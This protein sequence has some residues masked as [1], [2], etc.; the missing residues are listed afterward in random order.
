MKK[1]RRSARCAVL[2]ALTVLGSGVP[3]LAQGEHAVPMI[4]MTGAQLR[5]Q[6]IAVQSAA[7]AA[8]P[9]SCAIVGS[10]DL[11]VSNEMLAAFKARD[12]TLESL[13]LGITSAF[14]FDPESGKPMP[15]A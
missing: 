9:N 6:G 12:F 14:R 11:S 7:A 4:K 15:F 1:I 13:C 2:A 5:D 8:L 3:G 10:P